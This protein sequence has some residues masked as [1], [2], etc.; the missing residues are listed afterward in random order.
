MRKTLFIVFLCS[1]LSANSQ[2]PEINKFGF[3]MEGTFNIC[4]SN[5]DHITTVRSNLTYNL[6]RFQIFGGLVL[7]KIVDVDNSNRNS[8]N[9]HLDFTGGDVGVRYYIK[10]SKKGGAYLFTECMILNYHTYESLRLHNLNDPSLSIHRGYDEGN[11]T[12]VF[13][14]IIGSGVEVKF[15]KIITFSIDF[16]FGPTYRKIHYDRNYG[17]PEKRNSSTGQ[18]RFSLGFTL[19]KNMSKNKNKEE[20]DLIIQ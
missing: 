12:F 16:G 8:I 5:Q 2:V 18:L 10:S 7:N 6:A 20:Q 15:F 19:D 14:P 11:K 13:Q 4:N 9:S 3:R 1:Y 17:H